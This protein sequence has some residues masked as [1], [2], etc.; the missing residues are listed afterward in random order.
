MPLLEITSG[1]TTSQRDR[2]AQIHELAA[3]H[4]TLNAYVAAAA[5]WRWQGHHGL[6][7]TNWKSEKVKI[8]KNIVT[9]KITGSSSARVT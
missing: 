8:T 5:P 7:S 9:M 1:G 4:C 2:C 3:A 6:D